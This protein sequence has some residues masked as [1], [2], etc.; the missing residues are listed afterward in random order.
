MTR[1]S[2]QDHDSAAVDA[3]IES[4]RSIRGFLPTPVDEATVTRLLAVASRAPSGSNIQPWKAHVLVGE[5]LKRLSDDLCAAHFAGEPEARQYE[6]YPTKWRAPYLDRRRKVGWQ[7]YE[8]AGVARG[9]REAAL[10]QRGRNYI[11]FGAPMGLIFTIDDDLEQGSWLD[12]GMF[13][14]SFM[15]AARG[16]GL[17]TCAQAAIAN[18]PAIVRRHLGIPESEMVI[19]GMALGWA[20]PDEPTNALVAD[21][22]PV[23][24]FTRF[25]RG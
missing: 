20:D 8:L 6:Y 13:L 10:H 18:Y 2:D 3:A 22:E 9:D 14:Q 4:R 7:L 17:D 1:M 16:R 5:P 15:V 21:R 25:H 11:F 24:T 12:Y 19:C 23:E